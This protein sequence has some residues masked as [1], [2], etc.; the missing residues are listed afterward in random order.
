MRPQWSIMLFTTLAGVAQGF[1]IVL[2]GVE[3]LT[4]ARWSA[5]S[6]A[7]A[8][9]SVLALL[10]AGLLASVF[11]LGRPE[12][13]WRAVAQWRSSWLSRE[14]IVLP[15]L[16]V[17]VTV[18]ALALQYG[19]A[20]DALA[21]ASGMA[22]TVLALAL[23]YC[24]GMIYACLKML[25]EWA[26]PLTPLSFASLGAA[27]GAGLAV[28][29][30]AC[31]TPLA[32]DGGAAS[33]TVGALA[34]VAVLLNL[35]SAIVKGLWWRRRAGLIPRSTLQSALAI[36]HPVIRQLAMGMTGGSFNTREFFHQARPAVLA[37]LPIV[38]VVCGIVL[39]LLAQML[40]AAQ[41]GRPAVASLLCLGVALQ[42]GGILAERWLFFAWVRHPQNLYYQRV[43]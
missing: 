32:N 9:W 42:L 25:Q 38:M 41:P 39:P 13:A 43:S 30:F 29:W 26:T 17:A 23:W 10:T 27:S 1:F 14:V 35:V 15:P 36:R 33:A 3:R 12:R 8:A 40:A 7:A 21:I 22:G 6:L 24:T 18:H 20:D 37:V 19:G 34:S 28:A 4:V 5:M 16:M 31:I 2:F 11:H